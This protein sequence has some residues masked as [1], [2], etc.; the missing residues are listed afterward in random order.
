MY[1]FSAMLFSSLMEFLIVLYIEQDGFSCAI[2]EENIIISRI[3]DK[4]A[5]MRKNGRG[6]MVKCVKNR[7]CTIDFSAMM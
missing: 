5:E 1:L 7:V 6:G 2:T 3:L 4:C